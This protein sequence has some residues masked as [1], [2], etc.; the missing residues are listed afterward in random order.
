MSS[1]RRPL[2]AVRDLNVPAALRASAT[3]AADAAPLQANQ[4]ATAKGVSGTP[5]FLVG[6]T[7]H[8]L[9]V[10]QPASLSAAPFEAEINGLLTGAR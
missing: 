8:A 4:L 7:D 10:F 9:R 6:R 1:R 2:G 3:P 5:I